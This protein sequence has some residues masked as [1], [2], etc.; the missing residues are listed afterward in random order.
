MKKKKFFRVKPKPKQKEEGMPKSKL[1]IYNAEHY[2]DDIYV[3]CGLPTLKQSTRNWIEYTR[4]DLQYGANKYEK[5]L[6]AVLIDKNIHFIHQAP[7]IIDGKIYF[8]DFFIP[9]R[10]VI[11]EVDGLSHEPRFAKSYDGKRDI[12]FNS[13]NIRT[14]R[15]KNSDVAKTS[16]I[17]AK[18][19]E[20]NIGGTI[21]L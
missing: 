13:L 18:L 5:M 7:F 12:A 10:R 6:A 14:V 4:Y 9:N 2:M 15:I 1:D 8:A 21:K 20:Y 17:V 11:L 19:K 16:F 3:L